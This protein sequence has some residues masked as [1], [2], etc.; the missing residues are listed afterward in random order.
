MQAG[1]WA[2]VAAQSIVHGFVCAVVVEALIRLWRVAAPTERLA[3]R[4]LAVIGPL[5]VSPALVLA[6]PSRASDEFRDRFAVFTARHWEDV[7]V[8]GVPLF[9]AWLTVLA[10]CA[11]ALLVMDLRPLVRRRRPLAEAP[12]PPA[13]ERTVEAL[14]APLRVTAP[15][16]RFLDLSGPV[17]F[18]TGVRYPRIVISRGTLELLDAEELEAAIAHE[19]AHL[20][21][22]DPSVSWTLMAVRCLLFFNPAVQVVARAMSRDA[23]ARADERAGTVGDRVALASALLKLFRA[24]SGNAVAAPSRTL[25]FAGALAEPFRRARTLDVESRCLRLL[26]PTPAERPALAAAR[27]VLAAG[28]LF[29]LTVVIA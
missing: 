29:L 12:V 1:T 23:E 3:L 11:L 20:S 7:R 24:T 17:L 14:A 2:D 22:R 5:A 28:G 21:A 19:L 9:T 6:F 16:V 8:L 26:R 10:G 18:C 4:L 13:L 15:P 27:V 25:P